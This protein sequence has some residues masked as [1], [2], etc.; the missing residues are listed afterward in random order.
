MPAPQL[1]DSEL[2]EILQIGSE[3]YNSE[4]SDVLHS[5]SL[6]SNE[7]VRRPLTGLMTGMTHPMRTPMRENT[8]LL[9]AQNAVARTYAQTPLEVRY[10]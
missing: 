3:S 1:S 7:Q 8:V 6:L 9:E 2:N 5:N 10:K 4:T